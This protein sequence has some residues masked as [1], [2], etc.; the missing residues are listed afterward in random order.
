MAI[1]FRLTEYVI[2]ADG[3]WVAVD[4]LSFLHVRPL[5]C[6]SCHAPVV[7]V[8]GDAGWE[9]VHRPRLEVDRR[10]LMRCCYITP[11]PKLS[12]ESWGS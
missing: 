2:S 12:T 11:P 5:L 6:G 7:V 8:Q 9:L 1:K 10:H 4:E 3:E